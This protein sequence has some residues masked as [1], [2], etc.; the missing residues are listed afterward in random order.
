M[1]CFFTTKADNIH[2]STNTD[3]PNTTSAKGYWKNIDCPSTYVAN[4][5]V[6][7]QS[8]IL[9]G[10][11]GNYQNVGSPKVDYNVRSFEKKGDKTIA[12]YECPAD[13]PDRRYLWRSQVDVDIVGHADTNDRAYSN[14]A[15]A[16]LPRPCNVNW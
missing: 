8:E 5:S 7:L 12:R 13:Q 4:V 15:A 14:T 2:T 6:Q 9:E 1:E 16:R 10:S 11:G 3:E